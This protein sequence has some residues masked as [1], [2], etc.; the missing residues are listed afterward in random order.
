MMRSAARDRE[1]RI[2]VVKVVSSVPA[3]QPA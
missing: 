2:S 1:V 3:S